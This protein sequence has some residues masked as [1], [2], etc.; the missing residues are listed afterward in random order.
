M[1]LDQNLFRYNK[2]ENRTI[3]VH[4]DN[5]E[6]IVYWRK[7]NQINKWFH[8]KYENGWENCTYYPVSKEMLEELKE[9]CKNVLTNPDPIYAENN[10][11]T[12]SGFFYGS[13]EFDIDYYDILQST[14]EDLDKVLETTDFDT[15]QIYYWSWW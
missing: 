7:A 8:D 9:I 6:E 10:L 5:R 4:N 13:I 1:G 14:I 2:I 3:D 11:P 15:Q 12:Q